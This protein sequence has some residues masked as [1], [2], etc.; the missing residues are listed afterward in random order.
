MTSIP[1]IIAQYELSGHRKG[2]YYKHWSLVA[3][4]SSE[5]GHIF[6]VIG[7][8]STFG[9]EPRTVKGFSQSQ[10]LRGGYQVGKIAKDQLP[11]LEEKLRE[12]EIVRH[13]ESWDCQ[14]WV[15]DALLF[16]REAT[17][18]VITANIGRAHI[19]KELNLEFERSELGEPTVE[20][21]LFPSV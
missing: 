9:Y 12:V 1:L 18:G 3:L 13:D 10:R 2:G 16:L 11:W 14:S 4:E 15:L 19:Q 5:V 6:E 17:E 8:A 21:R 7:D 20:D